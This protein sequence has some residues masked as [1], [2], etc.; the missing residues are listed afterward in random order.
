MMLLGTSLDGPTIALGVG[1]V[2]LAVAIVSDAVIGRRG[3]LRTSRADRGTYWTIVVAQ[4]LAV[5]LGLAA[6]V[7]APGA[8]L[9]G[10]VSVV[11][12]VAMVAG[13]VL[14]LWSV[15]ALGDKFQRVVAV[16]PDLTLV[17]SG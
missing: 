9:S 7:V 13:T 16:P 8:D 11:G 17:T 10:W 12:I 6:R 4:P 14:R 1:L 3:A 2:V 15:V 5:V